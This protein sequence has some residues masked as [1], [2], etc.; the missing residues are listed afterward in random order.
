VWL[1]GAL[2]V[3]GSG[4]KKVPSAQ[5][6]PNPEPPKSMDFSLPMQALTLLED[7]LACLGF[8]A[9]SGRS[10]G[11]RFVSHRE[12]KNNGERVLGERA[13][14]FRCVHAQL[15]R[16]TTGLCSM[17]TASCAELCNAGGQPLVSLSPARS[18]MTWT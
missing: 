17:H 14:L 9:H 10:C 13:G 2:S 1:D 8:C 3:L 7:G 18:F 5:K 15:R 12:Q 16:K 4:D 11:G 6:Y